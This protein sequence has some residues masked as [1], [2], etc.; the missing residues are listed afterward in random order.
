MKEKRTGLSQRAYA[1]HRGVSPR[2]VRRAIADNRIEL[3]PDGTIDPERAD[4]EW[5]ANTD[6]T[7]RPNT[8]ASKLTEVRTVKELKYAKLLDVKLQRETGKVVPLNEV[9]ILF[10]TTSTNIQNA[11]ANLGNILA[12]RLVGQRDIT[13]ITNLINEE[14]H[15]MIKEFTNDAEQQIHDRFQEILGGGHNSE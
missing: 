7:K 11:F 14:V 8:G 1:E 13:K 10:R 9:K 6:A 15:R 3:L 12:P 4:R 2:A 5:E